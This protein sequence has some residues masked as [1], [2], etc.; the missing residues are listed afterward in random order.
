[1]PLRELAPLLPSRYHGLGAASASSAPLPSDAALQRRAHESTVQFVGVQ[2]AACRFIISSDHFGMHN[3]P[4]S[5]HV[6]E[7]TGI[8]RVERALKKDELQ[9][10]GYLGEFRYRD[11]NFTWHQTDFRTS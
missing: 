6:R 4:Q 7:N 10:T 9:F 3:K 1:M 2:L 8:R 11:H 5:K